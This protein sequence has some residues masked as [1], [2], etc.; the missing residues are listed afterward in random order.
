MAAARLEP[1]FARKRRI[2]VLENIGVNA[3]YGSRPLDCLATAITLPRARDI[4]VAGLDV[5]THRPRLGQRVDQ[6]VVVIGRRHDAQPLGAAWHG[7]I[8]DRLDV[9]AVVGEDRSLLCTSPNRPASPARCGGCRWTSPVGRKPQA[10]PSP[11]AARSRWRDPMHRHRPSAA[12]PK[13]A[14]YLPRVRLRTSGSKR[15]SNHRVA[16][17]L[18][19]RSSLSSEP[20]NDANFGIG[21]LAEGGGRAPGGKGPAAGYP[22]VRMGDGE[23]AGCQAL[24]QAACLRAAIG[25]RGNAPARVKQSKSQQIVAN[26]P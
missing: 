15:H 8:V 18:R 5:P 6:R 13:F 23:R 19:F 16:S 1:R 4:A 3:A 10:W 2:C 24:A 25:R 21:T 22:G 14:A 11:R 17:V 9:D 26:Y 7:R 12:N 20:R